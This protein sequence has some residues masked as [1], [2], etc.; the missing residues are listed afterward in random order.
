MR[1]ELTTQ[2]DQL[3]TKATAAAIEHLRLPATL[4]RLPVVCGIPRVVNRFALLPL[5]N[6]PIPR[7]LPATARFGLFNHP[8]TRLLLSSA[9][10]R[11]FSFS[12]TRTSAIPS[13]TERTEIA[14]ARTSLGFKVTR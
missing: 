10:E 1:P 2:R 5:R 12:S 13:E 8:D 6:L 9:L 14:P 3:L 11:P 7:F 4:A